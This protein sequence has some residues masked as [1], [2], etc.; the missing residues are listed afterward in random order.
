[1]RLRAL[2]CMVLAGEASEHGSVSSGLFLYA[3]DLCKVCIGRCGGADLS[4]HICVSR[5]YTVG[6]LFKFTML[7]YS[8]VIMCIA[9]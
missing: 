8:N 1:M 2:L 6:G 7:G 9:N 4:R 3:A 5:V